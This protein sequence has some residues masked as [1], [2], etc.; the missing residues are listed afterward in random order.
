MMADGRWLMVV[1]VYYRRRENGEERTSF[2]G[3]TIFRRRVQ[4]AASAKG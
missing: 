4:R 2:A 1:G 3:G